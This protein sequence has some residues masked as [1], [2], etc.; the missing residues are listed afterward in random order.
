MASGKSL[1][2]SAIEIDQGQRSIYAFAVDGKQIH[3]FAAVSRIHRQEGTL[4]GYQRPEVLAHVRAIRRYLESDG[5]LL[6]NAI[7]MAFDERVTFQPAAG[8]EHTGISR[9]GTLVIPVDPEQDDADKPGWVVDGQ[10]R[11]AAIRDADVESFPVAA[12]GFIARGEEEQRSQ[13]ILVNSTKPL[14]KGLIHELLPETTGQLPPAYVRKKIPAYLMTRLNVDSDSPFKGIIDTPTT[15]GGYVKDN[16]VL[17]MIENSLYDGV[18]YQYRDPRDGLGDDEEML[19]HLKYFWRRVEACWPEAWSLPPRKSRLTHGAGIQSLGYVMDFLTEGTSSAELPGL[20][21]DAAL[22]RLE[23]LTAWTTGSWELQP[24]D[25]R[26]W[27][28]VQ[29]TPNDVRLLANLFLGCLTPTRDR[30]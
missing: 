9:I 23:P 20:E 24:G 4:E 14:P 11:S 29:N 3:D 16:S 25:V 28:G 30:R 2:L 8:T 12:V 5:A 10:Q 7:V 27:N 17:K 21:I 19:Q 18:L 6:P 13:F 15:A 1:R 22:R 26:R